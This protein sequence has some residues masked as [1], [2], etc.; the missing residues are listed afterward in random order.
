VEHSLSGKVL[1]TAAMFPFHPN[2][3]VPQLK[4]AVVKLTGLRKIFR[5]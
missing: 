4:E 3:Y 2:H 5:I 1:L